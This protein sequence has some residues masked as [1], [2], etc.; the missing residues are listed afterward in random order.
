MANPNALPA[1]GGPTQ[2]FTYFQ[3]WD[4]LTRTL[5]TLQANTQQ[6][7]GFIGAGPVSAQNII[8]MSNGFV[9]L[10]AQLTQIGA[11]GTLLATWATTQGVYLSSLGSANI[12]SGFSAIQ[13]AIT[14]VTSWVTTNAPANSLTVVNGQVV[15][16]IIPQASLNPLLTLLNT[17]AQTIT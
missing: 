15:W 13:A 7:I 10:N 1:Y 2:P 12:I 4:I 17:L 5:A 3:A 14:G 11:L 6:M 8:Q 9:P 16:A